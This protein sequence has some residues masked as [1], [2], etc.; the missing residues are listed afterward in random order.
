MGDKILHCIIGRT[1]APVFRPTYPAEILD[2]PGFFHLCMC[3]ARKSSNNCTTSK[4]E[5]YDRVGY[6]QLYGPNVNQIF[7]CFAE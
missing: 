2:L 5:F 1:K 3:S 4:L 7:T 6:F